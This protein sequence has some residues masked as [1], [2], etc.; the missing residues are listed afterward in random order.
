[1]RSPSSSSQSNATVRACS[2]RLSVDSTQLAE[3]PI[4]STP[5]IASSRSSSSRGRGARLAGPSAAAIR[6]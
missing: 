2:E 1:M 4:I 3:S 6:R 5:P